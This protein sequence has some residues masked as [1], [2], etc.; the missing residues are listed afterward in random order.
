MYVFYQRVLKNWHT[1]D[2]SKALKYKKNVFEVAP[3][4]IVFIVMFADWKTTVYTYLY[5]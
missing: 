2:K 3:S 5:Y 4:E 1:Y